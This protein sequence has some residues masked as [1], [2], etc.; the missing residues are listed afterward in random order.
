MRWSKNT[1]PK[2][3]CLYYHLWLLQ[4]FLINQVK[5]LF[6]I[7]FLYLELLWPNCKLCS[8]VNK[9]ILFSILEQFFLL[10]FHR[11]K[12]N[13]SYHFRGKEGIKQSS[14]RKLKVWNK[15]KWNYIIPIG[16][17]VPMCIEN[18]NKD[19]WNYFVNVLKITENFGIFLVLIRLIIKHL[20]LYFLDCFEHIL[21]KKFC[22][23]IL[24]LQRKN[25]TAILMGHQ[26]RF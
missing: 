25:K 13:T 8:W 18:K 15:K 19:E 22:S 23:D 21:L 7:S 17:A 4:E 24:Q 26:V 3:H 14:I 20:L 6:Y 10:R 16:L 12:F 11:K 1:P 2:F 9:N 5:C